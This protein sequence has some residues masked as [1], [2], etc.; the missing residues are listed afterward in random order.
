MEFAI[1]FPLFIFVTMLTFELSLMWVDKHF[2]RYAAF[3]A[4]RT[5]VLSDKTDPCNDP[6]EIKKA[7]KRVSLKMASITPPIQ[8]F[9]SMLGLNL[10]TSVSSVSTG[11][12]PGM[13]Q[14][15]ERI[16]T[17]Y[18]TAYAL[19]SI[20]KCH[21][22]SAT[23][24][25]EVTL[26]YLRAPRV[27]FVK[28]AIWL[29]YGITELNKQAPQVAGSKVVELSLGE[30]FA[31][32]DGSS[33]L[34]TNFSNKL[35][36]IKNNISTTLQKAKELELNITQISTALSSSAGITG[37]FSSILSPSLTGSASGVL[38]VIS[39][40]QSDIQTAQSSINDQ[41]KVLSAVMYAVPEK[42]R[43]I[44]MSVTVR[45]TK[46]KYT[47]Q[48]KDWDDGKAFLVAPFVDSKAANW[49]EWATNMSQQNPGF[50]K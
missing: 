46:P 32:I 31:T 6:H 42:L 44:P 28:H 40:V 21:W 47:Q 15:I 37:A 38:G 12:L 19:N 2:M 36:I 9:S 34:L 1:V 35:T 18:P 4:A 50:S 17:R 48:G 22:D 49:R 45:L 11:F 29:V 24:S 43:F 14:A 10:G 30:N 27:P 41:A 16:V 7:M 5:L 25:V 20:E 13:K 39:K 26:T 23:S 3:E 8:H 33:P